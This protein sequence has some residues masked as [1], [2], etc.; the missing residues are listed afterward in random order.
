[1]KNIFFAII[2]NAFCIYT[3]AHKLINKKFSQLIIYEK[4]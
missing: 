3:N 1:M 2:Y 4:E